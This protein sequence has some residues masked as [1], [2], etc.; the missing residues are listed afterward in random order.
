[1]VTYASEPGGGGTE[2]SSF[3]RVAN[4]DCSESRGEGPAAGYWTAAEGEAAGY[5]T[6][7]EAAGYWAAAADEVEYWAAAAEV[8]AGYG[9]AGAT[10]AAGYWT[11]EE[12]GKRAS[13]ERAGMAGAGAG[14]AVG[15]KSSGDTV[16]G[17]DRGTAR[18]DDGDGCRGGGGDGPLATRTD[19]QPAAYKSATA[20]ATATKQSAAM[21]G[22]SSATV[23]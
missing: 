1:M 9:T 3:T 19:R 6:A 13:W 11:A 12:D 22:N 21:R 8:A 2:V 23:T 16:M 20:A 7:E 14:A 4:W 10:A 5:W 17:E 15:W 18:R